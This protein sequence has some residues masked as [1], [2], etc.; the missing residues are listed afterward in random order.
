[1]MQQI[2]VNWDRNMLNCAKANFDL[3]NDILTLS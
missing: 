3:P 1:M 2:G